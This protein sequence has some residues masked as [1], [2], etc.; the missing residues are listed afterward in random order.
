MQKK[1]QKNKDTSWNSVASW[2]DELLKGDDSYQA[3]V[4][5][6]NL[7]RFL[8]LKKDEKVDLDKLSDKELTDMADAEIAREKKLLDLRVEFHDNI[9]KVL[10]PK[11]VVLLYQ[12]E[13]EF[14]KVL[15]NDIRQER[16]EITTLAYE[17]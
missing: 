2:Y 16:K 5:L 13:K 14:K 17:R 15:L 11:K 6:P 10:S 12:A 4:V 7:L 1:Q 9:K 3:K 8:N